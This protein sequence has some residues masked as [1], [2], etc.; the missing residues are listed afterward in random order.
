MRCSLYIVNTTKVSV[1]V[2]L[3]FAEG[4]HL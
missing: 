3:V 1:N 4:R 2:K